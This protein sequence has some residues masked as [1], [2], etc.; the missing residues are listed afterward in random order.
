[1]RHAIG[2]SESRAIATT[3]STTTERSSRRTKDRDRGRRHADSRP[4]AARDTIA[5]DGGSRP[6]RSSRRRRQR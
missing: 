4:R 2:G 6:S 3:R 1:L 5:M